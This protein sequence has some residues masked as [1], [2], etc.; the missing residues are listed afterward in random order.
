MISLRVV[1]ALLFGLLAPAVLAAP[2]SWH[3][4]T[5]RHFIVYSAAAPDQLRTMTRRL[6]RF[7]EVMRYRLG[8]TT[9]DAGKPLTVFL[10]KDLAAVAAAMGDTGYSNVAGFYVAHDSGA[11]AIAPLKGDSGS[12][13]GKMFD[14]KSEAIL[15]H[16][17]THHLTLQY[18]PG[19][20]PRWYTEGLAELY[21]TMEFGTG[22]A[23]TIG[24]PNFVRMPVLRLAQATSLNQLLNTDYSELDELQLDT[25]YGKGWL[26]T[27]YLNFTPKYAGHMGDFLRA[28]QTG[29]TDRQALTV[30]F[31][32]T[33][34][35]LDAEL[36]AYLLAAHIPFITVHVPETVSRDVRVEDIP[37]S[38]NA[39]MDDFIEFSVR[40]DKPQLKLVAGRVRHVAEAYPDDLFAQRL[41]A[42]SQLAIDHFPE[43]EHAADRALQIAPSDPRALVAKG[44]AV[45]GALKTA[46]SKDE[47][48]WSKARQ[49]V[50]RANHADPDDALPLAVYYQS[51]LDA[52]ET[53]SPRASQALERASEL[54][55]QDDA[56]RVALATDQARHG[57]YKKA[58]ITIRPVA[59]APHFGPQV[60]K[61]ITLL[62]TWQ[63]QIALP[64]P[65]AA[66]GPHS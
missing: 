21:S 14:L 26:L 4:A 12:D 11:L 25:L 16:E 40:P 51:F 3:R 22:D 42:E 43:A 59:A 18:Y 10:V 31:G 62:R 58:I 53:P 13:F 6:E 65:T 64:G 24:K 27:H 48:A 49:W 44:G 52:G 19:V 8:L 66:A 29:Q 34:S 32:R 54:A 35:Q 63:N 57:D 46:K 45:M 30:A 23:V 36:R 56:L 60:K 39:M 38:M 1:T 15:F 9:D 17:Y 5:S 55:P 37:P 33:P 2:P 20:Y 61:A 7:D 50:V 28:L 47:L 41:L